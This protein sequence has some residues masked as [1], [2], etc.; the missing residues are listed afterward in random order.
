MIVQNAG[1]DSRANVSLTLPREQLADC[2][3][4][5]ESLMI[6]W[7][8]ATSSHVAKIAKLTVEGVGLRSHTGVGKRMFGAI[9]D[10]G[11][12][13]QMIATSEISVSAVIDA[14]AG[15]SAAAAVR[16]AFRLDD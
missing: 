2:V 3:D 13:V 11:A 6:G 9:A 12:N 14:A 1:L 8:Q 16:A 7:P 5:I 15:E 4:A 10:S